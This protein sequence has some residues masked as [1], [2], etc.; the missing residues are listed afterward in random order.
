MA[1]NR[2]TDALARPLAGWLA[3]F[4][5]SLRPSLRVCDTRSEQRWRRRAAPL[6]S[7]SSPTSSSAWLVAVKE[8]LVAQQRVYMNVCLCVCGCYAK[9]ETGAK[10][11]SRGTA[12]VRDGRRVL[13]TRRPTIVRRSIDRC[14]RCVT[15]TTAAAASWGGLM[16]Q[17]SDDHR[18]T[19]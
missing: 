12:A 6:R 3:R 1:Y 17:A 11:R 16:G 5:I 9:R 7:R 4:W 10:P 18:L 13:T 15:T 19:D 14:R 8:P 2:V